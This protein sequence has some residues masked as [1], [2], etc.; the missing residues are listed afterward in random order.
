MQGGIGF[1]SAALQKGGIVYL[2]P[3]QTGE[4][5]FQGRSVAYG[6]IVRLEVSQRGRRSPSGSSV[7]NDLI[8]RIWR[9]RIVNH[10]RSRL[11]SAA[12]RCD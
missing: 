5:L 3:L 8:N 11:T 2:E 10:F 7:A 9:L 4:A 6:R 1:Q 12:T